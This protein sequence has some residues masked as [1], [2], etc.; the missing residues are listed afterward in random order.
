MNKGSGRYCNR[1][2]PR[3][4]IF[5]WKFVSRFAR[6]PCLWSHIRTTEPPSEVHIV[7]RQGNWWVPF[8]CFL[9]DQL[10]TLFWSS[11]DFYLRLQS[12]GSPLTS[13]D[14]FLVRYLLTSLWPIRFQSTYLD[15]LPFVC[16]LPPANEVW[17]NVLFSHVFVSSQGESLS[18]GSAWQR[19]PPVRWR[20]DGRH[21][22]GM[23]SC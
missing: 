19:P 12:Q 16:F 2:Y 3:N 23:L 20:A 8:V 1:L 6:S 17:G 14:S 9:V 13:W 10:I 21:P 7:P 22:T 4:D 15:P 18:E 11:C 5:A